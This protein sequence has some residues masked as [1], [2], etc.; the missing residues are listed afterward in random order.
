MENVNVERYANGD[1]GGWAGCVYPDSRRWILFI[2][3]DGEVALVDETG[4][5]V[6]TL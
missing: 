1:T 6:S 2:G 4:E 3:V 5:V